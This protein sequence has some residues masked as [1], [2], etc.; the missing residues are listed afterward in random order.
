MVPRK[1]GAGVWLALAVCLLAPVAAAAQSA[2][3]GIVKDT[4]GATMP[5]VTV[6]AS[7]DVLIEKV[8]SAVTDGN[9]SYRIA[10]LRPGVY[11]VTFTLPGFK[12]YRRDG[13][14]LPAEFTA[15]INAELAVGSLEETITVTGSS[16]VV[17]VT[18]AAK[19]VGA[20][21]R[22]HRR[23]P[24]RPHHPGHGPI[25]GRREPEP[26]RHRRRARHAADLHVDARHDARPTPPCW[27]TAR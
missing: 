12:T 7:S 26:A 10:D 23:D 19:T 14:Q 1:Q 5:G 2:I 4:T 9:G 3:A 18:T 17:D 15:T 27:S 24:D 21:P 13:L 6:E 11:N 20:Q 22:S 16:P 25:G 8:K